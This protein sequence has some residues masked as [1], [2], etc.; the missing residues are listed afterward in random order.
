M[1]EFQPTPAFG[2]YKPLFDLE[3][4]LLEDKGATEEWDMA[5]AKIEELGLTLS[6]PSQAKTIELFLLHVD[7]ETARFKASFD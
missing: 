3:L 6:Y 4:A 2:Q 1:C 7:G 5:Y